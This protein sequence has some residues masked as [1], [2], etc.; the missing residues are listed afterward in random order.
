M[1][2]PSVFDELREISHGIHPAILSEGGLKPA[3]NALRRRSAV[4]G[5]L[6]GRQ[7]DGQR[8]GYPAGQPQ[9]RGGRG[10]L[11]HQLRE[12]RQRDRPLRCPTAIR[13]V[14]RMAGF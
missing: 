11:D 3:L 5:G 1:G 13:R 14:S 10:A 12:H 7:R 4:P 6:P 8:R 9:P 2:W